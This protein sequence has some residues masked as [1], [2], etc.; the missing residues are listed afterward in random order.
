MVVIVG[1][2]ECLSR[3]R[4]VGGGS[5]APVQSALDLGADWHVSQVVLATLVLAPLRSI[6]T[7][8]TGVRFGMAGRGAALVSE[9]FNSNTINLAAGVIVPA[10]FVAFAP[11]TTTSISRSDRVGR[12]DRHL[13]DVAG[14]ATRTPAAQG[15]LLVALYACFVAVQ[16]ASA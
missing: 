15:G 8:I 14:A 7:A 10:M 16:L 9:T 1:G 6:P 4:C 11:A 12:D 2:A 13:H 5:T 3:R